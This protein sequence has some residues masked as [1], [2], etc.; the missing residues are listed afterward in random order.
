MEWLLLIVAI[1]VGWVVWHLVKVVLGAAVPKHIHAENALKI[2]LREFGV[3]PE[4]VGASSIKDLASN[5]A[6]TS[7]FISRRRRT[8]HAGE[9]LRLSRGTA[10]RIANSL[11]TSPRYQCEIEYTMADIIPILERNSSPILARIFATHSPNR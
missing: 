10:I 11:E 5:I 3:E 2:H 6:E 8:S 1:P 7:E 9:L 4:E